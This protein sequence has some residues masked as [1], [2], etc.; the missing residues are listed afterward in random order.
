MVQKISLAIVSILPCLSYLCCLCCLHQTDATPAGF[1]SVL[2]IRG[3]VENSAPVVN[4]DRRS[5]LAKSVLAT[6]P[7]TDEL[8]QIAAAHR[9]PAPV[10]LG[11]AEGPFGGAAVAGD[12]DP[13]VGEAAVRVALEETDIATADGLAA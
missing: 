7:I 5:L 9:D 11:R 12:E 10:R 8:E 1:P 4:S 2:S 6:D 3:T 13:A